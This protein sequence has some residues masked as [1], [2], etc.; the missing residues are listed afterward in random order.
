MFIKSLFKFFHWKEFAFE[1]TL[2]SSATIIG[3]IVVFFSFIAFI[4]PFNNYF[5]SQGVV[6]FKDEISIQV[7]NSG[8]IVDVLVKNHELVEKGQALF[9]L[10]NKEN[11][12]AANQLSI[13]LRKLRK[14]RDRL[15]KLLKLGAVDKVRLDA[16]Q[17]EIDELYYNRSKLNIKEINSPFRGH[18]YHT[19][20]E[21]DLKGR[22]FPIG[23]TISYLYSQHHKQFKITV[24]LLGSEKYII[25]QEIKLISDLSRSNHPQIRGSIEKINTD[26]LNK[27]VDLICNIDHSSEIFQEFRPGT[28]FKVAIL[29]DSKSLFENF[30]D[31]DINQ[32]VTLINI[33][34]LLHPIQELFES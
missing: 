11:K 9:R 31:I 27:K 2:F 25:G 8:I 4:L 33:D 26:R 34:K 32:V 19:S 13:R 7:E 30:F 12:I 14:E 16:K 20:S 28:T 1:A 15:E 5:Y 21:E 18:I 24:P 10:Q 23:E 6:E 22:F 17:S 3:A 29:L